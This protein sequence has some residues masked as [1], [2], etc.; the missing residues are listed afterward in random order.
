MCSSAASRTTPTP[1]TWHPT[2]P[3]RG[4]RQ[5]RTE[6]A[7]TC[8]RSCA[9]ATRRGRRS[10]SRRS[11]AEPQAFLLGSRREP[12]RTRLIVARFSLVPR[13]RVFFD[14]FIEAGQNSLRAAQLLDRMMTDWPDDAGLARDVL[15]AEQEG[16]R[17]THDI[18]QR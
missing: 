6:S 7:A 16:D 10:S 18:V 8:R 12:G 5:G 9:S 2:A 11:P 14:L 13:D 4:V 1:G 17:I 15:K 3:G